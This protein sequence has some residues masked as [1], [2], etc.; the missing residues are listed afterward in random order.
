MRA[1]RRRRNALTHVYSHFKGVSP[2]LELSAKDMEGR[3]ELYWGTVKYMLVLSG[4]YNSGIAISTS[5]GV[6]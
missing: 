3:L 2:A 1:P 5:A 6:S 4:N